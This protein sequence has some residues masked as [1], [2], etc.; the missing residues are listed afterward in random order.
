MKSKRDCFT[1]RRGYALVEMLVVISVMAVI[2]SCM[3]IALHGMYRADRAARRDL[4]TSA[5]LARLSLHLRAD[6]HA[7]ARAEA[8]EQSL[9]L[10]LDNSRSISYKSDSDRVERVVQQGDKV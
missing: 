6:V 5:S 4:E 10:Q 8:I 3:A 1:I 7:A 2:A 9:T